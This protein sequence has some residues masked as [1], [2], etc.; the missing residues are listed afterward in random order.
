MWILKT[1]LR[2]VLLAPIIGEQC[3]EKRASSKCKIQKRRSAELPCCL[4]GALILLTR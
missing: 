4:V 3:R 1:L 2:L